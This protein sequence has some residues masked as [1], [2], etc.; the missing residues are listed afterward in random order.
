M[1]APIAAHG[2]GLPVCLHQL[3]KL[4]QRARAGA[5]FGKQLL[6]SS[7]GVLS[8]RGLGGPKASC[9]RSAPRATSAHLTPPCPGQREED[10][11][12]GVEGNA[13]TPAGSTQVHA[14]PS[15][16]CSFHWPPSCPPLP[17]PR[18]R[19]LRGALGSLPCPCTRFQALAPPLTPPPCPCPASG[20]C[21]LP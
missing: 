3:F 7:K 1:A 2:P 4:L 9:S 10:Q 12:W 20:P 16:S 5:T 19:P 18:P 14:P 13:G 8:Y 15:G 6:I 17:L 21:L 11:Q